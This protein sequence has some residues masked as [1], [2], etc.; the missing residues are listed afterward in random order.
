MA[1]TFLREI[2]PTKVNLKVYYDSS[3]LTMNQGSMI[4]VDKKMK[5]LNRVLNDIFLD[6]NITIYFDEHIEC[7]LEEKF[8][9][10]REFLEYIEYMIDRNTTAN[11]NLLVSAFNLNYR[12]W[13][14]YALFQ[15]Y[16]HFMCLL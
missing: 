6:L 7:V 13:V 12:Y 2:E 4:G 3:F 10:D 14:K 16:S 8:D 1:S 9:A 11:L 15:C 5:K